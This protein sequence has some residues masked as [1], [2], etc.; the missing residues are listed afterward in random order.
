MV[1]TS[2]FHP[3][4]PG[5]IPGGVTKI[6][7]GGSLRKTFYLFRETLLNGSPPPQDIMTI[8]E[9]LD[10]RLK[11]PKEYPLNTDEEKCLDVCGRKELLMRR[12]TS[13]KFRKS[14]LDDDAKSQIASAVKFNLSTN[15]PLKLT[16][17]FGGYKSWR[18]EGFPNADLAEFLTISYVVRF[19]KYLAE[20][21]EPG[22]IVQF[23]SDDV[24]IEK[25]DNYKKND[26]DAYS[27]TFAKIIEVFRPHLP[28]NV[29]LEYR[30]VVPDL[31][32]KEEY[33]V[34]LEAAVA[35]FNTT[36]N[37]L[38]D[39]KTDGF[40]FN[41]MV[42]GKE[43]FS[44]LSE[45][46]LR[47]LY[48][49]LEPYSKAYLSIPRRRAFNRGEDKIVIFSQKI[50]NSID[51][52]STASSKAKFWAG[53]GIVEIG[54]DKMVDRILSPKQFTEYKKDF[55]LEILNVGGIDFKVRSYKGRLSFK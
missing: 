36:N 49:T 11:N 26:L 23:T 31:Y 18:V 34:D 12:L 6:H 35:S 3:G 24:I 47:D 4:N 52:G 14:S 25:I 22:V 44:S 21:Y 17:P 37:P 10:Y 42:T 54:D 29:K 9:F 5:S 16:Y 30:R 48:K 41:F 28:N 39:F 32:D 53:T 20:C 40:D 7:G 2:G 33:L 15:E 8:Q 46:E 19:A 51:I 38:K 45:Q 43:D 27:E 50:P 13:G 55:K 1:R